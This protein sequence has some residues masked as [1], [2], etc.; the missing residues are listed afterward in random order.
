MKTILPLL[1]TLLTTIASAKNILFIAVD[2]L[3]PPAAIEGLE[4]ITP[5]LDRLANSG[6]RLTNAHCQQAVCGP[7]RAS[8]LTGMRPDYTR[9][10]D[11]KTKIR[12]IHPDILSLPQHFRQAGYA[13]A[14]VGKIF[15]PRSVDK[16]V[17]GPSWSI[18]FANTWDLDYDDT[19]GKPAAHYQNPQ[20]KAWAAEAEA[21]G[22]KGWF[23]VNKF[24]ESRNAW[25]PYECEDVPDNAY[26]DGAIANQGVKW[27]QEL[28]QNEEPFFIAVGF[29][30]PHLPFV[31]PKQ[32][33]DRYDPEK[34]KL[35]TLT[36]GPEGS[37]GYASHTFPELRTYSGIPAKGPVP[38]ETATQLIHGY[39]ACVSYIDAQIGKLLQA[40]EE[41]G[42][43]EETVIVFW[44]DHGFHLGDHGLWCKHTN[45]EQATRVPLLFSG[46]GVKAGR[47]NTSPVE[48]VDIFP[49]LCDLSGVDKPGHLQGTSLQPVL[50]GDS[51]AVKPFAVSQ[52]PRGK[53]MGYALR[54]DRYR[55]VAWYPSEKDKAPAKTTKPLAE[56]LFDYQADP[57][58]SRNLAKDRVYRKTIQQLRASMQAFMTNQ[59]T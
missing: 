5:N 16:L 24:L 58:E 7:S 1:L 30:K 21:S 17:D 4:A 48:L 18:P 27:I 45:Y 28:S 34:I 23:A 13:T 31:A 47:E 49:T 15:D 12:D 42:K 59:K 52:Y 40:L 43:R 41:S 14:G 3:K 10:W 6:T 26:D 25:P 22:K 46:P 33:W 29:K 55:Y 19:H 2:D 35:A 37:P 44:G 20:I 57:L 53:K 8:L 54:T 9:V 50:S 56:E 36:K 11:L 51:K 38:D 32:Y 39:L